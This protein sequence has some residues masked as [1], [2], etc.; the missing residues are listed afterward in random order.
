MGIPEVHDAFV[1][2]NDSEAQQ[3]A[4]VS[5]SPLYATFQNMSGDDSGMHTNSWSCHLIKLDLSSF[6]SQ[7]Q[8]R[9]PQCRVP[10]VA[11]L[12]RP[13]KRSR[14]W[15]RELLQ[16]ALESTGSAKGIE[17]SAFSIGL[18]ARVE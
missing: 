3:G 16:L 14:P 10:P 12:R 4:A 11:S 8:Q 13:E 18:G 15:L 2:I 1:M 5:A 17:R 7:Q 6:L 9:P